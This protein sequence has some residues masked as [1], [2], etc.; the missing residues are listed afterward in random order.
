[1]QF[2]GVKGL[3]WLWRVFNR[4]REVD[5][6][7]TPPDNHGR[8]SAAGFYIQI[9]DA[10]NAIRH[11]TIPETKSLFPPF[12]TFDLAMLRARVIGIK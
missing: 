5:I 1:M 8:S 7:V 2:R 6:P 10:W 11:K 3:Q 4:A 12:D 9:T